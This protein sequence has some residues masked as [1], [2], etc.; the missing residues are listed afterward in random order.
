MGIPDLS[1]NSFMPMLLI[2]KRRASKTSRLNL[3]LTSVIYNSLLSLMSLKIFDFFLER[4]DNTYEAWIYEVIMS[5][6]A[7]APEITPE[8]R[9]NLDFFKSNL[10]GWLKDVAY[11]HKY[12]VISNKELRNVHDNFS[13]ALAFAVANYPLGDFIIQRV[14]SED[15]EIGFLK[16]AM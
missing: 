2:A 10:D 12:V 16:L 6:V 14:I 1:E 13:S 4:A 3:Q 9:K 11:R 5:S 15:E 8:M 7:Y